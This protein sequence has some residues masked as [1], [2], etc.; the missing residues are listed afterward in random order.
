MS[1]NSSVHDDVRP[2]SLR[3]WLAYVRPK[4]WGVAIAPV[5]AALALHVSENHTLRWDVAFF[6]LTIAVLMQIITNMQNDRGYT[7]R[8]LET[9]N[10]RG[11]PRATAK[12][13]IS[14][15]AAR[16][17]LIGVVGLAFLNTVV[18]VVY[19]GP[20]FLAIGLSSVVA[21]YAYMGGPK[22][23]AYTPF[24]ELTV[25]LFFGLTAVCGTYYLQADTLSW[26]AVM[27]GVALGSVAAAVLAVN[28]WRDHVHDASVGRRTLAVV[29]PPK[30]FVALYEG[31]L[32]LPYLLILIMV[33]RDLSYWPYLLVVFTLADALHLP[34]QLTRLRHEE[35]NKTMFATVLLEVKFALL[36][37][38]GALAQA[39]L[40]STANG[41]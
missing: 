12:G 28:N 10:R 16:R 20:V 32:L 9:E 17:A 3:A 27:L 7:K 26:H 34:M 30:L 40:S 5:L 14:M 18:L 29:C 22:P 4:T 15:E 36:F 33:L 37:A 39:F 11:L 38:V 13:W 35:L 41:L 24:G 25:L 19:G 31:M 6:T 21:A 8:K 2:N 23:I 1:Q